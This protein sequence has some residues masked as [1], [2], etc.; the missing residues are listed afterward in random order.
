[1]I[2]KYSD[3]NKFGGKTWHIKIDS[4]FHIFILETTQNSFLV[5]LKE[6]CFFNYKIRK[7]YISNND[8]EFTVKT[9]FDSL[10]EYLNSTGKYYWTDNQKNRKL[11][12]ILNFVQD[13]DKSNNKSAEQQKKQNS[14]AIMLE[15]FDNDA[16][17][18]SN[19]NENFISAEYWIVEVFKSLEK[20]D[21][22]S[23]RVYAERAYL[24]DNKNIDISLIYWSTLIKKIKNPS[25][26]KLENNLNKA[27][28]LSEEIR[29]KKS[30]GVFS[31]NRKQN[32]KFMQLIEEQW[33]FHQ[34]VNNT[35]FRIE[36]DL[37]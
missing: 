30:N 1:M 29:D 25:I 36:N 27:I 10:Q 32:E 5:E 9:A 8:F 26:Q 21:N 6:W 14:L 12:L 11:N 15:A 22:E 13:Y 2:S 20:D 3:K 37:Y 24:I 34:Y 7:S 23:A 18:Q 31:L 16:E 35:R 19:E 17:K 33:E 28:D 4:L